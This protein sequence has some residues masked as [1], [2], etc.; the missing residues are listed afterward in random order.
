MLS[1]SAPFEVVLGTEAV[2]VIFLQP[3]LLTTLD[4]CFI[5]ITVSL[6]SQA[7]VHF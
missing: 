1:C 6:S 3:T 5:I 7:N 2:S 4:V